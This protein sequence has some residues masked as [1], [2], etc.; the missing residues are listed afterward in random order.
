MSLAGQLFQEIEAEAD[1]AWKRSYEN[2]DVVG[3]KALRPI[4]SIERKLEALQYLDPR[5]GPVIAQIRNVLGTMPKHGEINGA[6]LFAVVGLLSL[7][8]S[9]NAMCAH[10][11]AVLRGG[12]TVV[13]DVST[14]T[15]H[16]ALIEPIETELEFDEPPTR[17]PALPPV[18]EP[19]SGLW[20]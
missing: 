11:D 12:T 5:I 4:F 6:N 1:E 16:C 20:F 10:G 9:A 13:S 18:A 8:R 15:S 2:R 19:A 3:Q 7:L 17:T 14:T